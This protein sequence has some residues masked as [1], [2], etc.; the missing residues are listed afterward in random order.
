MY[1]RRSQP[2]WVGLGFALSSLLLGVANAEDVPFVVKQATYM[3]TGGMF[4]CE[5]KLAAGDVATLT[6]TVPEEQADSVF[7]S[8]HSSYPAKLSRADP[9]SGNVVMTVVVEPSSPVTAGVTYRNQFD[10]SKAYNV[11]Y[12]IRHVEDDDAQ[13]KLSAYLSVNDR[14]FSGSKWEDAKLRIKRNADGDL[15]RAKVNIDAGKTY[16]API[17]NLTSYSV[18][19][20]AVGATRY[21]IQGEQAFNVLDLTNNGSHTLPAGLIRVVAANG[22]L[23]YGTELRSDLA[24]GSQ[25]EMLVDRGAGSSVAVKSAS[26]ADSWYKATGGQHGLLEVERKAVT[27]TT[28]KNNGDAPVRVYDNAQD[29]YVS[30]DAGKSYTWAKGK[31]PV[32]GTVSVDLLNL[33][34][35]KLQEHIAGLKELVVIPEEWGDATENRKLKE[36][37]STLESILSLS[38]RIDALTVSIDNTIVRIEELRGEGGQ[39]DLV[40]FYEGRKDYLVHE[41]E[42]EINKKKVAEGTLAELLA[43]PASN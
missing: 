31:D 10:L 11:R 41:K 39:E 27:K 43:S 34:K 36:L 4:R 24:A 17:A 5:A 1:K 20:S 29:A 26:S 33:S 37:I 21:R 16:V 28:F 13:A 40:V 35:A 42:N 14:S 18:D 30:V 22:N 32:L 23:A 12:G 19:L 6:L 2:E 15:C 38:S 9:A 8:I 3:A 25:A 7:A